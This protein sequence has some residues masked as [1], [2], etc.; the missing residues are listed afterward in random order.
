MYKKHGVHLSI[1]IPEGTVLIIK[2]DRYFA[3]F[4]K[5]WQ[6]RGDKLLA[7]AWASPKHFGFDERANTFSRT[8][9][10]RDLPGDESKHLFSSPSSFLCLFPLTARPARGHRR[11]PFVGDVDWGLRLRQSKTWA[12]A[13]QA[14]RT[15]F[16]A[17]ASFQKAREM[18]W[19]MVG[20][21]LQLQLQLQ[22]YEKRLYAFSSEA[23]C[24]ETSPPHWIIDTGTPP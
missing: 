20:V 6:A 17:R 22:P 13:K 19:Q 4:L 2:L 8:V 15:N 11:I 10:Q 16:S 7:S 21:Q 12:R 3:D 23:A 18:R 1:Q 5:P 14:S 9:G 24:K